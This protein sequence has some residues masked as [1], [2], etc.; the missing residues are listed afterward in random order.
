[1]VTKD[2][3]STIN[4]FQKLDLT[5]LPCGD[6]I[7]MKSG[8]IVLLSV[9]S[10]VRSA[11]TPGLLYVRHGDQD[12]LPCGRTMEALGHTPVPYP[13]LFC[14]IFLPGPCR[15]EVLT[16]I[17]MGITLS[18]EPNHSRHSNL[19]PREVAQSSHPSNTLPP[20]HAFRVR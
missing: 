9:L 10:A 3:S 20:I 8:L 15:M 7:S 4:L 13:A 11:D 12:Y 17:A 18:T 19:H 14:F 5:T 16:C 2:L 6:N 1:M